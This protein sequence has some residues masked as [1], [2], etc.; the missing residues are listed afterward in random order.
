M[1][2]QPRLL[3]SIALALCGLPCL[4]GASPYDDAQA[5]AKTDT[6]NSETR[7]CFVNELRPAFNVVFQGLLNGC[8]QEMTADSQ[9][10]FGL[11][12]TVTPDGSIRQVLWRSTSRFTECLEPGLRAAKLPPAPKP[13]FFVGMAG[14]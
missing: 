13:E 12:F 11:V 5:Q 6:L 10:H 7:S 14:Q 2:Q 9:S 4:A 1:S 8:A 3:L